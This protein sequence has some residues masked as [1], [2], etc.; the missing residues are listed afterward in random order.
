MLRAHTVACVVLRVG[1]TCNRDVKGYSGIALLQRGRLQREPVLDEWE[2]DYIQD[3][4]PFESLVNDTSSKTNGAESVSGTTGDWAWDGVDNGLR[5]SSTCVTR[6]DSRANSPIDGYTTSPADTPCVFG[7]D[8]RDE[9][10]HCMLDGEK[11]GSFGWCYTSADKTSWGSCSEGCPLYGYAGELGKEIETLKSEIAR[12]GGSVDNV[13]STTAI[14][15]SEPAHPVVN[16]SKSTEAARA[17][18]NN[19]IEE[20]VPTKSTSAANSTSTGINS[21][22]SAMNTPSMYG[23]ISSRTLTRSPKASVM[24]N[25]SMIKNNKHINT[26]SPAIRFFES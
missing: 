23:F 15:G 22:T 5:S 12:L 10:S 24:G 11:Y 21:S 7:V 6:S 14:G 8:D 3:D 25:V 4:P 1:A 13:N 16:I 19:S 18:A 26:K 17:K 20:Q 9:G 2:K